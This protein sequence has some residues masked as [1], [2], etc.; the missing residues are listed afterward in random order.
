MS[1]DVFMR[2]D[3]GPFE[4][5]TS[6]GPLVTIEKYMYPVEEK[7]PM[8]DL[9]GTE[10]EEWEYIEFIDWVGKTSYPIYE[11]IEAYWEKDYLGAF[12]F[13]EEG[14]LTVI[15]QDVYPSESLLKIK[16]KTKYWEWTVTGIEGTHVQFYVPEEVE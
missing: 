8:V 14:T 7:V 11:V 16:Y 10:T 12:R 6:G 5:K 4:L 2:F 1:Q 13:S 9:N 3:D 15:D